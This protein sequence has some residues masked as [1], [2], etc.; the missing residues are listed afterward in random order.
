[1]KTLNI[2]E[3][4]DSISDLQK[5][6]LTKASTDELDALKKTLREELHSEV[7]KLKVQIS[8]CKQ[9]EIMIADN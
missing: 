8:Y 1:M 3:I 4:R 7:E 9:F 2:N 5:K 6:M